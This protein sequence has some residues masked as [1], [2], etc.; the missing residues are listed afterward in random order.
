MNG[1]LGSFN[2][3]RSSWDPA[4]RPLPPPRRRANSLQ[5]NTPITPPILANR[6]TRRS[7]FNTTVVSVSRE[8]FNVIVGNYAININDRQIMFDLIFRLCL[9]HLVQNKCVFV[10]VRLERVVFVLMITYTE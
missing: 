4:L 9:C 2:A 7:L 8:A 6:P 1:S 3:S 5:H 10:C